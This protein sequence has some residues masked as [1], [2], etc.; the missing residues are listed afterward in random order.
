MG[1]CAGAALPTHCLVLREL[2]S[3]WHWM[4]ISTGCVSLTWLALN[5]SGRRSFL[6][7]NSWLL[8]QCAVCCIR[9]ESMRRHVGFLVRSTLV[10]LSLARCAIQHAAR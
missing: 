5:G 3:N 8:C 2:R 1:R 6:P 7:N 4:R 10:I 9:F